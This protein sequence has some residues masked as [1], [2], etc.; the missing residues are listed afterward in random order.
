M[1]SWDYNFNKTCNCCKANFPFTDGYWITPRSLF[2]RV[3]RTNSRKESAIKYGK[4]HRAKITQTTK[5]WK[6]NNKDKVLIY[7]YNSRLYKAN[8]RDKAKSYRVKHYSNPQSK[9]KKKEQDRK[10]REAN[11]DKIRKRQI[12]WAKTKPEY[13]LRQRIS[14]QIRRHLKKIGSHKNKRSSFNYLGYSAQDLKLHL[15]K[16][17]ESWMNWSNQGK[18]IKLKWNDEDQSTWKWQIDHIIPHS[19]FYYDSMDH[20]DFKKCWALDNLRPFSAKENL[21][22]GNKCL[23]L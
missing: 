16:H 4:S 2:C 21:L 11:G 18:Y 1:K 5:E 9:E 3:C 13:L 23:G 20:P 10:Y 19:A 8:N 22:K 6:L 12:A 17:F 14:F 15:E 7:N